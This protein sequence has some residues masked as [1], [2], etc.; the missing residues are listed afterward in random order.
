MEHDS[1]PI[2]ERS[3][4]RV[5][6]ILVMFDLPVMTKKERKQA[7][8]FRAAL[9]EIGFSMA[10]YSVYMRCCT[11]RDK[12]ESII[13]KVKCA[14]PEGGRVEV[15]IFTDKQYENMIHL[16]AREEVSLEAQTQQLVF[17]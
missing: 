13:K 7:S 5:M 4:Y 8:G 3:G 16:Y 9:L 1:L 11:S 15:L 17:F 2:T 14:L 10:Q 6:W 12:K